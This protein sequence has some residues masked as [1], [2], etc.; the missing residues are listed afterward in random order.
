[1]PQNGLSRQKFFSQPTLINC[2]IAFDYRPPH[3]P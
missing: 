3:A 1:L 2:Q